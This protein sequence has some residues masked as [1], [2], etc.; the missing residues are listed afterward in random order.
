MGGI[1]WIAS[2]PKSG[3]T[4]FRTFLENLQNV[5][6]HPAHINELSSNSIASSR[7]WID[8]VLGVETADLTSDEI[9]RLRPAVYDWATTYDSVSYHKIHDANRLTTQ[10]EPLI[11]RRGTLGAVY[12][13]RNPLD[14]A[15]SF[16]NHNGSTIDEAI[17]ALGNPD[18]ALA[19]SEHRWHR[20]V[21]QV[22]GSWSDHVASWIDAPDLPCHVLR[23]EDMHAAALESFAAAARFLKLPD[24]AERVAQA[25]R[26]SDFSIVA[27]QEAEVGFRERPS[28][29][30]RFFRQG[31]AG[32]WRAQLTPQQVDR[33]IADHGPMMQRFGYLDASGAPV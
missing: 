1:Y 16:A 10:G 30:D 18:Y 4:W 24:D 23:Y 3:N 32:G 8:D 33:I 17:A 31:R 25:I 26:H 12:I 9:E 6:D 2:Y 11:S 14:V 15:P 28:R 5:G 19:G 20:Q 7:A 22:L 21:R 27:Q 29:A 13:L